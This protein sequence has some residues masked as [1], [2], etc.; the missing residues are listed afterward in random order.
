MERPAPSPEQPQGLYLDKG[1]DYDE[2]RQTMQE[3]G[4]TAH[5]RSPGEGGQP[6]K[7]PASQLDAGSWKALT[8]G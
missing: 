8:D 3:F 4:F 7:K 1:Y 5:I 2:V 6:L